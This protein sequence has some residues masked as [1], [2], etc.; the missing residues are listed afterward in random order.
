MIGGLLH[1]RSIRDKQADDEFCCMVA[2][3]RRRIFRRLRTKFR[4]DGIVNFCRSYSTSLHFFQLSIIP[5]LFTRKRILRKNWR[6]VVVPESVQSCFELSIHLSVKRTTHELLLKIVRG[7]KYRETYGMFKT[8]LDV[9]WHS[10][11]PPIFFLKCF[12]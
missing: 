4:K 8:R 12:S 5:V 2:T 1:D 11:I 10:Y 6:D 9:F 7:I 3:F